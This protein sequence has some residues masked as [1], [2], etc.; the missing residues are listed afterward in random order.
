[1]WLPQGKV[2]TEHRQGFSFSSILRISSSIVYSR[3]INTNEENEGRMR[4]RNFLEQPFEIR[5]GAS[6]METGGKGIPEWRKSHD[7]RNESINMKGT[8]V[9]QLSICT[10]QV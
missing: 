10:V 5:G 3:G 8:E 9:C 2:G 6:R 4:E 7:E 1:M